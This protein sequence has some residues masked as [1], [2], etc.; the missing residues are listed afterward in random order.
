MKQV[1]L[2]SIVLIAIACLLL[3]LWHDSMVAVIGGLLLFFIAYNVLEATLPSLISRMA[4]I[5]AK[6]T[7]MGVYSTSQFFGAFVG[8]TLGGWCYGQYDVQGIFFGAAGVALLWLLIAAGMKMPVMRSSVMAHVDE[9]V[10]A[11]PLERELL[12]LEG[13]FEVKVV[14]EEHTIFLRVDK[15]VYSEERLKQVVDAHS[16]VVL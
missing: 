11:E 1:F 15:K 8:G 2:T 13:V 14:P 9:G 7:A 16:A 6:G 10:K 3:A 5:D 4:P 12:A